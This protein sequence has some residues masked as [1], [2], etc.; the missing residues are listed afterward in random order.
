MGWVETLYICFVAVDAVDT[1]CHF[2]ADRFWD[3]CFSASVEEGFNR[4]EL[5]NIIISS[6]IAL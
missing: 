3:I 4:G 6:S 1:V 2:D 5:L